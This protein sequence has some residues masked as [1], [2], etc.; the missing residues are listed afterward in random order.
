MTRRL[1]T[2]LRDESAQ[3]M[4][5]YAIIVG[6]VVFTIIVTFLALGTRLRGVFTSVRTDLNQMPT[7]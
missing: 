1:S 4:T 6:T 2:L 3:G 5:E 7:S